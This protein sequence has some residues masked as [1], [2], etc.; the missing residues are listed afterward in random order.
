[1]PLLPADPARELLAKYSGYLEDKIY[2]DIRT[3]DGTRRR[4]G[5]CV[6]RP[7]TSA[8]RNGAPSRARPLTSDRRVDRRV[9]L[10]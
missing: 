3:A 8:R 1:M 10:P 4:I 7:R 9:D 2:A 5:S 6:P